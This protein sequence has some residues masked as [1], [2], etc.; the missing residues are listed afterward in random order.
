M[1]TTVH[2]PRDPRNGRVDVP[3]LLARWR[4]GELAYASKFDECTGASFAEIEDLCDMTATTL[5][6]QQRAFD[7]EEHLR[8][9]LRRGIRL[10]A[11]RLH[12]DHRVRA[13]VLDQAASGMV[14]QSQ[15][16]ASREEPEQVLL[17]HE[18]DLII[19]EFTPRFRRFWAHARAR[20]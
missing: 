12:R 9:A 2:T 6:E 18:D 1:A 3:V 10:R 8:A 4:R 19:G 17:A 7:S 5:L 16:R 14:A 13:H 15:L 11:L 20:A